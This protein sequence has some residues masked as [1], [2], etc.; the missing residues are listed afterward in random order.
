MNILKSIKKIGIRNSLFFSL[1]LLSCNS[2]EQDNRIRN[3]KWEIY[4]NIWQNPYQ[5]Y[6]GKV[7][8]DSLS[9][10]KT[11]LPVH[12]KYQKCYEQSS[13]TLLMYFQL[14]KKGTDISDRVANIA[15]FVKGHEYPVSLIEGYAIKEIWA[16]QNLIKFPEFY[17][18]ALP[19]VYN[20]LIK[21]KER[22]FDIFIKNYKGKLN[23]FL[24]E[25]A[26]KRFKKL[27]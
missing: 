21:Y 19:S 8:Q 27:K 18:K 13:D 14:S 10:E 7:H 1:F 12:I 16:Y 11:V 2:N 26:K 9:F 5:I 6:K 20:D 15:I 24:E 25:E 3:A 17:S 22:P 23:P 4:R